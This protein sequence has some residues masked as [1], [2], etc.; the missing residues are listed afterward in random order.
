[1]MEVP[2]REAYW[3]FANDSSRDPACIKKWDEISDIKIDWP[4]VFQLPFKTFRETKLQSFQFRIIQ[5]V[6]PCNDWLHQIKEKKDS[7]TCNYCDENDDLVHFFIKCEKTSNFWQAFTN[8]LGRIL[9]EEIKI[10]HH[11]IIFGHFSDAPRKEII[12]YCLIIAKYYI[13]LEKLKGNNEIN[14]LT[15]F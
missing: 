6:I 1:M 14:L 9:E 2:S 10:M 7:G 5:R 13:Y 11:D 4:N 3:I 15:Y 8:W 12:N